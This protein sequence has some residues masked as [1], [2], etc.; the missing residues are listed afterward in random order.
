[1]LDVTQTACCV[2]GGGPA[3]TMLSL[4][5]AR[6]GVRVILLE[7][8]KDFDRQFRG[9]TVHPS[10]LEILDQLGLAGRLLELPHSKVSGP[11]V[12]TDEGPFAPVD[13]TRLKTRFPYIAVM[14]QPLLLGF[15]VRE[16]EKSPSFELRM[17]A[18][19]LRLVEEGGVVRGVRYQSD[20]G[21][22]EIRA[23]LV[24]GADGRFS[25]VRRQAGIEPVK[26]SPPMDVLWFRLPKLAE[27]PEVLGGVVGGIGRGHLLIAIDRRDYW[28]VGYAIPKG[29]YQAARAAGLPALRETIAAIDPRFRKHLEQL[30]DWRELSLLSVESSRCR[31]W[32][33]AG[34][35][36]I[37]DAAHAMSPVGGVGIN[38][39]I[40]DAVE[41]AN[42]LAKPLAAGS[43]EIA[44]LAEVQH[45]RQWPTRFIQGTQEFIQKRLIT[46]ALQSTGALRIP[47]YVR[48][49]FRVPLVRDVPA[50]LIAFGIRRVRVESPG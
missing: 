35:L 29:G 23:A 9:D 17:G 40:Q 20:G 22:H 44:Q 50:R 49:L 46:G 19:V 13:L 5:L 2:V 28:Q 47:W 45:R 7:M 31:Q 34:L 42:V 24:V 8:H 11:A 25:M 21:W 18:E 15:L 4:L 3:G 26:T 33:K 10:T 30:T 1:M 6:R 16:A 43:V 37:G 14:H 38:Y 27:N 48:A 39:A 36:L 41:A 32:Y 12:L